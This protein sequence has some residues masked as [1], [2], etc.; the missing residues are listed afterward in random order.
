MVLLSAGGSSFCVDQ[1][2]KEI[3]LSYVPKTLEDTIS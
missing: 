3:D 1:R 2:G